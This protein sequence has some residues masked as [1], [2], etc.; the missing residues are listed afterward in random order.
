M[1]TGVGRILRCYS[2]GGD[3]ARAGTTPKARYGEQ[4]APAP[5]LEVRRMRKEIIQWAPSRWTS[6]KLSRFMKHVLREAVLA[7]TD[8]VG[9]YEGALIG[10]E[11]LAQ[12]KDIRSAAL[13]R[14]AGVKTIGQGGE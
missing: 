5:R 6:R 1:R 7:T 10:A 3:C 11:V 2:V 4:A 8:L 12:L 14:L 9:P 13:L